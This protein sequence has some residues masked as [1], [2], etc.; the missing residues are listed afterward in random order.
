[1]TIIQSLPYV[2][3][4]FTG[5]LT[6]TLA[7]KT[8]ILKSNS[9]WIFP[10][11]L[12]ALFAAWSAAAIITEGQL[13][14]WTEHTRNFWGYQIWFDLLLAASVAW[15]LIVPRAKIAGM[16]V[17]LWLALVLLSGSIGLLAMFARLLYLENNAVTAK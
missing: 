6:L 10:T 14:F 2:A 7:V 13:G 12:C 17:L 4:V 15:G 9:I 16:Q 1:M 3:A 8:D 11:V 5:I